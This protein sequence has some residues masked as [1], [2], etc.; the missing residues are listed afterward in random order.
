S[1]PV[2]VCRCYKRLDKCEHQIAPREV[3]YQLHNRDARMLFHCNCT[4]RLARFL[5]RARDLSVA[6]V[7]VLADHIT[8]DCFVLEP[9]TD[10]SPGEG[11]PHNCSTATQ[12]VRVPARHLKE[13]LRRWGPL[14]VTSK[15]ERPDWRTQDSGGSL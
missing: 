1:G 3:K 7:A 15:A 8:M 4:R 9:P 5:R 11:L 12:A 14:R 10:C 2:R 13:T 6:E